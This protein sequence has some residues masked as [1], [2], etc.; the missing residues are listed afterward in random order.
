MSYKITRNSDNTFLNTGQCFFQFYFE[1][2]IT[3]ISL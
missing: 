1:N 2:K 3:L